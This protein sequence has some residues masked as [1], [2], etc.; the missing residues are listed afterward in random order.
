ML[1]E[2]NSFEY[3]IYKI[4]SKFEKIDNST[5]ENT[6]NGLNWIFPNILKKIEFEIKTMAFNTSVHVLVDI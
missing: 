4:N 2:I 1:S 5:N 3:A 6:M